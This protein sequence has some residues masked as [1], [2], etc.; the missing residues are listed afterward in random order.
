MNAPDIVM[1]SYGR[2]CASATFFDDFYQR[3]LQSSPEVRAKFTNTDMP[4]Q[5][6]LLRQG[7][8]NLVLFSRG[9]PPTKLQALARSHSRDKLD[10]Q[11]HLYTHWIDAL[12]RT[13]EQ[14]DKQANAETARAWREVL[15]KGV[16]VI[17]AG[18]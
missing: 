3:F 4:A 11:P 18:Y 5:K 1:Q 16:E 7:I 13:V 8:L 2:C 6:L 14:H 17:Q 9:L 15:N 12:I 10:I